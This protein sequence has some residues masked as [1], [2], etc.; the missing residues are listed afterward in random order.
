[1]TR[2]Y[3]RFRVEAQPWG[4][5]GNFSVTVSAHGFS[6]CVDLWRRSLGNDFTAPEAALNAG[7]AALR[8][9]CETAL[10]EMESEASTEGER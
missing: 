10:R 9:L 6:G 5:P 1:M 7:R 4:L 8:E 2:R 3:G